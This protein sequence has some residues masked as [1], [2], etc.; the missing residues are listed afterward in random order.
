MKFR[1]TTASLGL[2]LSGALLLG[3]CTSPEPGEPTNNPTSGSSGSPSASATTPGSG[4]VAAGCLQD[5]GLTE[6]ADGQVSFTPGP[7]DWES[8][9]ALT[10]GTYSTYNSAVADRMFGGFAYFGTDGTTCEDTDFGTMELVS[11]DPMVIKY[12]IADDAVWSDGTPITINDY[13]LDWAAQNP[14]F[15]APGYVNGED[16]NAEAVFDHVSTSMSEYVPEGPKGEVGSKSFTLE[17][18]NPNPD[19]KIMVGST[20]PAH[21]VA[22]KSGLEPDA[23]AQAVLDRDAETVKKVAEWWNTGW[24]LAPGQMPAA[25]DIPVSGPYQPKQGAWQAGNSLTL[26]ANPAYWGPKPA[27]KDLVVRYIPDA[28][29]VQALQN[30]DV[31]AIEPQATI[32]T[33]GQLEQIGSAI[34]VHTFSSLT[35]EH[36]DF[37]FR[38]NSVFGDPENGLKLRQA[39]A[40]CVPRQD[41]VDTLIKPIAEDT[42]VMNAREVF[43]FQENYDEVVSAAYDGAYDKVDIEA[44]KALIAETGVTTPIDIRLGYRSGNERRA[45][46]V[47]L[48]TAS[49]KD[50][51]FNIVDVNAT[52]F[53]QVAVPAGD[54]EVALFAWAGS[55][56]ITSGQNI[57]ASTGGQNFGKFKNDAVDEAWQTLTGTLD[58]AVHL[59]QVKII[60]KELWDNLFG[61]PLY[62]HPGIA[63]TDA[64][65]TNVRPTATQSQLW[66][67]AQQWLV[68]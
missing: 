28:G 21:I 29:M 36:L 15:I 49:C 62:A 14:E 31:M 57:Y 25:E 48:I 61:I 37:N 3:A 10:A 67:N 39:F 11:E 7:G 23:L 16:E 43:P 45:N 26:E 40:L 47:A 38:E 63:A 19:W 17:Y 35:W 41:I 5:L 27:T 18:A 52:D 32:D 68:S 56:Q 53:M 64:R 66:W 13:L 50:A 55:G 59:E 12:T 33:V 6:T 1:R 2:V 42:V 58:T 8:Y 30:G 9:N 60:E 51:G 46:T 44:A 34:T 54:Y 65:L 20:M 4:D 24:T 22:K